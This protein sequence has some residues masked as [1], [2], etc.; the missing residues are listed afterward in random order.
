MA[1]AP[2]DTELNAAVEGRWCIAERFYNEELIGTDLYIEECLAA[3]SLD[4]R[5][6]AA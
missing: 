3:Q 5:E 6:F 4:H 1:I 2:L